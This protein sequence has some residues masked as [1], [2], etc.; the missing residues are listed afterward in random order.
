LRSGRP[1]RDVSERM[2]VNNYAAMQFI[3]EARDRLT[4]DLVREIHRIVTE[5]TLDDPRD[6]GRLQ[7]PGDARVGVYAEGDD[8]LLHQP[9]PAD[10]LAPRLQ[11]LCDFANGVDDGPY[12]PGVLRALVVHFMMGY[13]HFFIDGNGRT[14]RSLFYWT[15]LREGYWLAEYVTIST[16]LRKARVRYGMSFLDVETDGGDLTYFF[17]YHLHVLLRAVAELDAYITRKTSELNTARRRLDPA[18]G[19]FNLRQIAVLSAALKERERTWT[20]Q[21]VSR[22]FAVTVATAHADLNDLVE[23][24]WMQRR[25]E[26]R[27]HLWSAT[28]K[29]ADLA[30]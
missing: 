23:R 29:L 13:N 3:R 12:L 7:E 9:P 25:R 20:A 8:A 10:D 30:A 24:G 16:I 22:Q 5:G 15:L 11:A 28:D 21:G 26:G 6:A 27:R 18:A 14:A 19:E 17:L 4:P 2:I 1:P